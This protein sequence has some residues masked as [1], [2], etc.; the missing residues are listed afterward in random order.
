MLGAALGFALLEF[1]V[2]GIVIV[3]GTLLLLGL[4]LLHGDRRTRVQRIGAFLLGAGLGGAAP[5]FVLV[6]RIGNICNGTAHLKPQRGGEFSYECYSMETLW[7]LLAYG[8][9]ACLGALTLFRARRPRAEPTT[10]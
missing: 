3:P 8:A 10:R 5:L 7:A 9:L 6:V 1:G 2:F 4:S